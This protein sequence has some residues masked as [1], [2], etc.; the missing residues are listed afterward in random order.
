MIPKGLWSFEGVRTGSKH[1][2]RLRF[3]MAV[4][5]LFPMRF[6]DLDCFEMAGIVLFPVDSRNDTC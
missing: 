3:A 6:E 4:C 2:V 1:A 5:C